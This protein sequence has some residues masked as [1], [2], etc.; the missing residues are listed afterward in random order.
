MASMSVFSVGLGA[1][2]AHAVFRYSLPGVCVHL[3]LLCLLA[4][5]AS[6]AVGASLGARLP[7]PQVPL[8]REV[9][10]QAAAVFGARAGAWVERANV[11][12][13]WED[14]DASARALAYAYLVYVCLWAVSATSVLGAWLAAFLV[15]PL[16]V[17]L[18]G[19]A[20]AA[21]AGLGAACKV[22]AGA[23]SGAGAALGAAFAS[24]YGTVKVGGGAC[25]ALYLLWGLL[26]RVSTM[27]LG[28]FW[29]GG[30]R[31]GGGSALCFRPRSLFP[32]PVS[33]PAPHAHA[34]PRVNSAGACIFVAV[35]DAVQAMASLS[36]GAPV[37]ASA[38][39]KLAAVAKPH[40]E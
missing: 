34:P 15:T 6:R 29:K 28:A 1:W 3:V 22:A 16:Y 23:L 31:G 8:T 39:G 14:G 18:H 4:G 25:V 13:K 21:L 7:F 2:L 40:D 20:D 26:P 5:A 24:P 17:Q 38:V 35:W 36:S 12:L 9:V 30:G 27:I 11:L 10:Q 32:P 37:A 19:P 33:H